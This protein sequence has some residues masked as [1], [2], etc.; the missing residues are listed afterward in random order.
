MVAMNTLVALVQRALAP[1]GTRLGSRTER[2]SRHETAVKRLFILLFFFV[3]FDGAQAICTD[4]EYLNATSGSCQACTDCLAGRIELTPCSGSADTVCSQFQSDCTSGSEVYNAGNKT[5]E[6]CTK[7]ALNEQTVENCHINQDTRCLQ[8]C[9]DNFVYLEHLDSCTLDCTQCPQGLCR[10]QHHCL[11][12]PA[13]CYEVGDIYCHFSTCG[14]LSEETTTSGPKTSTTN[15]SLQPWGIGLIAVGVVIGIVAFS[16]CFLLMGFCTSTPSSR[17]GRPGIGSEESQ[18]SQS[19]LVLSGSALSGTTATSLGT[20]SNHIASPVI[21]CS[22]NSLEA[23]RQAYQQQ[24]HHILHHQIFNSSI[25]KSSPR[26]LRT[27]G[28]GRKESPMTSV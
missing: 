28:G 10:D 20:Q 9:A 1:R 18:N 21:T 12:E 15:I 25:I 2:T 16:A 22:Q 13:G 19:G 3:I 23:L 24:Q 4:S 8:K 6:G 17:R 26:S 27:G 5:C 7:C 14:E 11:C